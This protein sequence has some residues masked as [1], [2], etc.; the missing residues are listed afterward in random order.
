M[1]TPTRANKAPLKAR[2]SAPLP[3]PLYSAER[4][5][6]R[7]KYYRSKLWRRL[8]KAHLKP[9]CSLCE[10]EGR[11]EP[12]VVLD[13]ANP[14]WTGWRG[15]AAGPWNSLCRQHHEDKTALSDIPKLI[16]R[17]RIAIKSWQ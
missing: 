7:S 9:L 16:K 12:A 17:E 15:F 8:R 1:A 11:I 6:E 4:R 2:D 13:H 14:L 10:E 5:Q 3:L